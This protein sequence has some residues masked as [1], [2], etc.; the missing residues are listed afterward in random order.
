MTSSVSLDVS[1]EYEGGSVHNLITVPASD[2]H[3]CS[4]NMAGGFILGFEGRAAAATRP[5]LFL[6]VAH[7]RAPL[8]DRWGNEVIPPG[9]GRIHLPVRV[10]EMDSGQS[11]GF[12]HGDERARAKNIRHTFH[13]GIGRRNLPWISLVVGA[14]VCV[15]SMNV[16]PWDDTLR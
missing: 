4:I 16:L 8:A 11:R 1:F 7:S 9:V 13:A 10:L 5:L 14:A 3:P 15:P 12:R 6:F 2:L